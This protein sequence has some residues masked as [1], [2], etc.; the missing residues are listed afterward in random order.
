MEYFMD[1]IQNN[2]K[3]FDGRAT[4]KQFWM[5]FLFYILIYVACFLI[6]AML[7]T[8]IIAPIFSIAM[9]APSLSIGARR[10]HDIGKSGWWQLL[11]LIPLASLVLLYFFAQPSV[12]DNAFGPKPTTI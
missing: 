5:Y 7:G 10:L 4:R 11:M 1:A 9:L 2:Y 6:D 8:F 12:E 3:N